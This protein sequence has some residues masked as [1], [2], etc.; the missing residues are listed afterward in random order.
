MTVQF[1]ELDRLTTESDVTLIAVDHSGKGSQNEKDPLDVIRG[2]SAKGG[3]LDGVLVLRRHVEENAFSVHVVLRE[4]QPVA[5][6]VVTWSYPGFE[7]N[8]DLDPEDM[9]KPGGR[10]R[11]HSFG[12]LL[13]AIQDTDQDHPVTQT[14]W[15]DRLRMHRST[16]RDYASELRANGWIAT[17]GEGTKA[18][19]Y[20]TERGR[21]YL[22]GLL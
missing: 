7:F 22:E 9:K 5:P 1:N 16:L 12:A 4:L 11:Q 18:R 17:A 3:D 2:S 8:G 14:V 20:L 10:Q 15:A 19:Q 21:Q 6:F 13:R